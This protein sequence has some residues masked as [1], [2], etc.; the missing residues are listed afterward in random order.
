MGP[1]DV[2]DGPS[3]TTLCLNVSDP[4]DSLIK[5]FWELE[6]LPI[7]CHL[8]PADIAAEKIYTTTTTRLSSGRFVVTL[9]FLSLRPLLGDSK[10]LA[11]QRFKALEFRL[12]RNKNLQAQYAEFMHDYL[13]A[14]HMELIPPSELENPYQ[15]YIP[16]HCVLKPNSLTTK[17]RV[18][19]NASAKTSADISLNESMYTSPKLQPDIQ[20]VLLRFRLW[21]YLFTADIKQM[22]HQILIKPSDRDYLRILWRFSPQSQIDEYRLCTVTYGTSAAPFQAL[23]TVQ[24]LAT[25]N[26]ATWP[27]AASVLLNDTFVDDV[28]TG[29][30]T[31]EDTLEC[32]S[33]LISLCAM[34]QFQLR[35]W[36]SNTT[37]IL[38]T[39]AE[40]DRAISPS[41]LLDTS[42][43]SELRVLGLK[44]SPLAD[45]FFIY[46]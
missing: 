26:G 23:R 20:V 31:I 14:G 34:A 46:R 39:V 24:E 42:E 35:K 41:V 15:Y 29:G 11:L 43:Q 37:Q 22:Y 36:A 18:V 13:T 12:T 27:L 2:H 28:L 44:W 33:Q 10:T 9:P 7:T 45:I 19:F 5:K 16:H 40:E 6:E 8:S 1:T 30:N 25:V 38:Q 3:V 4:I 21:K 17:L 32:Q